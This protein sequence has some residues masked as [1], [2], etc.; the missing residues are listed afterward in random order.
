MELPEPVDLAPNSSPERASI[1]LVSDTPADLGSMRAILADL[2]HD[3]VEARSGEEATDRAEAQEFAVILL[4]VRLPGLGGFDT[5][6]AIRADERS[7]STPII[8]L[9]EDDASTGI[10][11]SGAMPWGRSMSW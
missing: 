7:R 5:A 10:R 8:F 1:L 9:A 4:D 3:L 6:E 11:S 2:G